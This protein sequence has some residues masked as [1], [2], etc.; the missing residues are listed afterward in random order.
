VQLRFQPPACLLIMILAVAGCAASGTS[1]H[2]DLPA[3]QRSVTGS[4]GSAAT[5]RTRGGGPG[6]THILVFKITGNAPMT[7][8]TYV[9][10]GKKTSLQV[11]ILPRTLTVSLPP[12]HGPDTWQL[13]AV[14]G[15]GTELITVLVDGQQT[16]QGSVSGGGTSQFSGTVSSAGVSSSS[17]VTGSAGSAG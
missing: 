6:P 8:V 17:Q 1:K 9:I 14:T 10:N 15:S 4:A 12:R 5:A 13:T 7:Q 2:H 11:S 3:S 16:S